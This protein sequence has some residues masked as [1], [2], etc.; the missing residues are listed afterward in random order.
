MF[1]GLLKLVI[2]L[3]NFLRQN[4]RIEEINR[5]GHLLQVDPVI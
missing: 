4:N 1:E 5:S 2:P 3:L